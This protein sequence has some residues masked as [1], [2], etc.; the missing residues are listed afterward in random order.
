M[1]DS[2]KQIQNG[3]NRQRNKLDVKIY[4]KLKLLL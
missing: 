3:M 4:R 2:L 1:S